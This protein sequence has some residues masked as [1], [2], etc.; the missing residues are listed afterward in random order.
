MC[1]ALVGPGSCIPAYA[2]R[3]EIGA[4]ARSGRHLTARASGAANS[5]ACPLLTLTP[6]CRSFGDERF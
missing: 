5:H 6:D 1:H 4:I 3:K 2:M